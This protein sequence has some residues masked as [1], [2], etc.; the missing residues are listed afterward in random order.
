MRVSNV[1]PQ[2][3][4]VRLQNPSGD[5][6]AT[7]NVNFIVVEEGVWTIDGV[8]IEAHT[9]LSTVTD[10]KG[11]WFGEPQ[12]YGRI[13][14]NPVVLG[15][16]M[17]ENDP[18]WSNFFCRGSQRTS[19]PS[20]SVLRTGK[21]VGE[22]S[23]V[24]RADETVGFIVFEAGS[25]TIGGV[26]FE[27]ALG[28]DSVKGISNSPPY[29]YAFNNAFA[30]A[31]LVAVTTMAAMDGNNGGWAMTHGPDQTTATTLRLVIDEG[32]T[33]D[34]ERKHTHE[35]VGYVVF[36]APFFVEASP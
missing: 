5:P 22:D 26:Q 33:R 7:E 18:S 6:V 29:N 12:A 3:F 20:S 17:T 32:Q 34:E 28:A 13:Y 4:D 27:A 19:P 31:P 25:G 16:V 30:S 8:D 2:S 14:T 35:Q 23:D 21:M 9:Y 11:S 36:E 15:Q 10:R 1:T 24:T